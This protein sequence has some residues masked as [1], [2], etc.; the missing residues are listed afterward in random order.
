MTGRLLRESGD[1]FDTSRARSLR[2]ERGTNDLLTL[3]NFKATSA[4]A[5]SYQ[6]MSEVNR[7]APLGKRYTGI[8]MYFSGFMAG[9]LMLRVFAKECVG[10]LS[11]LHERV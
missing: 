2:G 6:K 3:G 4:I 10:G 7:A 5:K 1:A 8:Y 11:I 9:F